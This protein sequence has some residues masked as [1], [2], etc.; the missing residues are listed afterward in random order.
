MY[1]LMLEL[2]C[3]YIPKQWRLG[4]ECPD[5]AP[6]ITPLSHSPPTSLD[7]PVALHESKML[8]TQD[9]CQG[10]TG[11][12]TRDKRLEVGLE[13]WHGYDCDKKKQFRINVLH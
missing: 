8:L 2:R 10:V 7:I 13:I 5:G 3:D 1:G 11:E 9:R 4:Q 6:S 12:R